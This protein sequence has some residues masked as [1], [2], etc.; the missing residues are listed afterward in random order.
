MTTAMTTAATTPAELVTQ[1]QRLLQDLDELRGLL[2]ASLAP[3]WAL[4]RLSGL[5]VATETVTHAATLQTMLK[6]WGGCGWVEASGAVHEVTPETPLTSIDGVVLGADL[7]R[8]DASLRVRSADRGWTVT[9]LRETDPLAPGARPVLV[10]PVE[11]AGVRGDRDRLRYR[12]ARTLQG[13]SLRPLDAWFVGFG[14]E[15]SR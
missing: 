3:G 12:L 2:P 1:L 10:Q 13:G 15:A 14:R 4:Q 5:L 8:E 7:A 9:T 11:H 6:E